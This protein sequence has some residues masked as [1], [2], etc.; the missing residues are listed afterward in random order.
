MYTT[1]LRVNYGLE[2]Y[3]I[4]CSVLQQF[5]LMVYG[6]SKIL[7][8]KHYVCIDSHVIISRAVRQNSVQFP[9]QDTEKHKWV[10]LQT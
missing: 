9:P 10:I 1:Q 2:V 4:I 5:M 3:H 6:P 8:C 7:L